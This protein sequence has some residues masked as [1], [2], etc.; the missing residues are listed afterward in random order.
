MVG[1]EAVRIPSP[2]EVVELDGADLDRALVDIE[3]AHRRLEAARLAV[4]DRAD[5][6]RRYT[7]DGHASVRGWLTALTNP[8]PVETK[9]R[10]QSMRALRDLPHLRGELAAG[11]IGVEQVRAIALLHANPRLRDLVVDGDTRLVAH[12]AKDYPS[13]SE[14]LQRWVQFGD[15]HG[16]EQRHAEAHDHRRA[17]MFER[18]GV[19]H[20]HATCGTGQGA[21]LLE[22]FARQ[23]DA[24]FL[25]DWDT[26]RATAD[27]T[28]GDPMTLLPRTEPQR[29][30]DALHRLVMRGVTAPPDATIPDPLV[31]I[32]MTVDQYEARCAAIVTATR[33]PAAT[34]DT[35]DTHRCETTTGIPI[36]PHDAIVASMLG[37]IR[38]VIVDSTGRVTD[39]GRRRR[40]TGAARDAV[41]LTGRRCLWPG[42]NRASH[43]N[44]ID[45]TREHARGGLTT[46][47]NGGPACGRHNRIK[48]TGYTAHRTPDG[49]WHVHRPDGT[50][51]T[52]PAAA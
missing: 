33:V 15:P 34:I 41:L 17:I 48:T 6:T 5:E 2:A 11:R 32:V 47:S 52:R 14:V 38:R 30:M 46:P 20:V 1:M 9:R 29:A 37:H 43:R 21:A 28:G 19:V 3:M 18:D 27:D 51:L 7:H 40:F 26:A 36:D 22:A 50:E 45:H 4:L 44:Q 31:N 16:T 35:I 42:C 25:A 10:L 12:A 24:E 23:C 8:S 49:T 39:L 13:F